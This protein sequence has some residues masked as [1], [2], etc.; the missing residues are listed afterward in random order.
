MCVNVLGI[1]G[2]VNEIGFIVINIVIDGINNVI[3]E[4]VLDVFSVINVFVVIIKI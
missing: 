2:N 1:I 3:V 4:V